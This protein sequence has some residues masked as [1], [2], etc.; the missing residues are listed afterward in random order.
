[1]PSSELQV[2]SLLCFEVKRKWFR[3]QHDFGAVIRHNA[4]ESR[5]C[6]DHLRGECTRGGL[7]RFSHDIQRLVIQGLEGAMYNPI[8]EPTANGICYD[9]CRGAC[10]RK[11]SCPW[12]HN[13]IEIAW[14]TAKQ[15]LTDDQLTDM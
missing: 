15:P 11:G 12:T 4:K 5:V 13:L 9:F 3:Y 8:K 7:C 6:F 14:S 10:P 1:M 2:R